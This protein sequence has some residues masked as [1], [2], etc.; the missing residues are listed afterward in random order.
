MIRQSRPV[1][2]D[3][4]QVNFDTMLISCILTER[5]NFVGDWYVRGL[6]EPVTCW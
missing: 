3:I 1:R 4:G 6:S 5:S 2:E